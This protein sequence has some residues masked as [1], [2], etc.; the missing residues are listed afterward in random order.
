LGTS[1]SKTVTYADEFISVEVSHQNEFIEQIPLM[2][3]E[4]DIVTSDSGTFKLV[5]GNVVLEII[6]DEDAEVEL[7]DK[8]YGFYNKSLKM[9]TLKSNGSLNYTISLS[10]L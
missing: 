8:E 6:F 1:G 7:V 5:R 10:D 4:E 9:L 3:A 2:V